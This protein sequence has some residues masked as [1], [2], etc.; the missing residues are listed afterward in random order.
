MHGLPGGSYHPGSNKIAPTEHPTRCTP[1]TLALYKLQYHREVSQTSALV[2]PHESAALC[3]KAPKFCHHHVSPA[4]RL[5]V[6]RHQGSDARSQQ[7]EFG[8]WRQKTCSL[9]PLATPCRFG[10]ANEYI[11]C[12]VDSATFTTRSFIGPSPGLEP[13]GKPQQTWGVQK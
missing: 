3:A 10:Q 5:R 9:Q 1:A 11:V 2:C 4:T 7:N 6:T 13:N 12:R 8:C